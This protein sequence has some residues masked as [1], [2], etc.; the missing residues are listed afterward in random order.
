MRGKKRAR[1]LFPKWMVM[2]S[3]GFGAGSVRSRGA[4]AAI[5]EVSP[6][7]IQ[8]FAR[9]SI[10]LLT[11]KPHNQISKTVTPG[12]SP[13]HKISTYL[14]QDASNRIQMEKH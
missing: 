13:L 1:K 3:G 2:F 14:F 11:Q 5:E 4:G 8:L 6:G 12:S 9:L 7:S 10:Q